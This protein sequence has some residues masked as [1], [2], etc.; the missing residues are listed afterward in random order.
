M[1]GKRKQSIGL[2]ISPQKI[3]VAQVHTNPSGSA[4]V[5]RLDVS[6]IPP[7]TI[8]FTGVAEA[9]AL[10]QVIQ[11][12]LAENNIRSRNISL[13]ISMD[14]VVPRILTLPEM[15][16]NE[17]MEVLRGEMENYATLTGSEIVLDYQIVSQSAGVVGVK[18]EVLVVAVPKSLFDSYVNAIEMTGRLKLNSIE[19]LPLAIGRT[20]T[21]GQLAGQE[22]DQAMLISVDKNN[23]MVTAILN[24][25]IRFMHAVETGNASL[26][27]GE[28]FFAELT[29]ELDSSLSYYQSR[30]SNE[31]RVN[32]IVLFMDG[33]DISHVCAKLEERLNIP[34]I[35][36]QYY[37]ATSKDIEELM[38]TQGLSAYAAIGTAT[39]SSINS[40][41]CVN[42]LNPQHYNEDSLKSKALILI[43]CLLAMAF[44]SISTALILK[45]KALSIMKRVIT[46]QQSS[47]AS[48]S[49]FIMETPKIEAKASLLTKRVSTVNSIL[50]R[51]EN[52]D[53]VN[54]LRE[55]GA[56]MPKAMW[57]SEFVWAND[58][59]IAINGYALSYD[60]IFEFKDT[61][62]RSQYFDSV[63]LIN[64]GDTEL[65]GD[66]F[67]EF[68]M[69]CIPK[70]EEIAIKKENEF[71]VSVDL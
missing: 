26:S 68:D 18:L 45:I 36:P 43:A 40:N 65:A 4:M 52:I 19:I 49:Q 6:D 48:D 3:A 64:A 59:N 15:P 50:N 20:L 44:L 54:I 10:S 13:T 35:S 16:R 8:D 41:E 22:A 71:L 2:Y 17:M 12:L 47:N 14:S 58:R 28:S 55:I 31:P 42:L 9:E 7:D 70:K 29:G 62:I 60:S 53:W 37:E 38:T 30:F 11:N 51:T 5:D 69:L 61:L 24:S 39:R 34:V 66:I 46:T 67:V 1:F 25:D 57:L 32:N 56:I 33:Y 23:S 63:K 27:E 21:S